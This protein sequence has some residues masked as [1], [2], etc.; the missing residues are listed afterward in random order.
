MN[1]FT[2]MIKEIEKNTK[3]DIVNTLK[4]DFSTTSLIQTYLSIASIMD[5]FKK[6]FLIMVDVYLVVELIMFI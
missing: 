5:T 2:L 3:D 6:F 4:C 1:F